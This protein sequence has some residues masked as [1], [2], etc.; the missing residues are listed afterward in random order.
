MFVSQR[1]YKI[2]IKFVKAA[3]LDLKTTKRDDSQFRV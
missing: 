3:G 1:K 2:I